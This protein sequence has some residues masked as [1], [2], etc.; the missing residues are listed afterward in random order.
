MET[1][2][3]LFF[4]PFAMCTDARY[5]PINAREVLSFLAYIQEHTLNETGSIQSDFIR[6]N[7]DDDDGKISSFQVLIRPNNTDTVQY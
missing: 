5:L 4:F 7:D 2:S 3:S 1:S 6:C